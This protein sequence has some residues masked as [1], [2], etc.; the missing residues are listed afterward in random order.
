MDTIRITV[1][2]SGWHV[3]LVVP[4]DVSWRVIGSTIPE[5]GEQSTAPLAFRNDVFN[6]AAWGEP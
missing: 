3:V 6:R 2:A 1:E 5:A 4:R